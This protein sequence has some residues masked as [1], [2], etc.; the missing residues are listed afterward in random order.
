MTTELQNYLMRTKAAC[1]VHRYVVGS[2][3][4]GYCE[5]MIAG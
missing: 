5:L 1:Y 4:A 2:C 3:I